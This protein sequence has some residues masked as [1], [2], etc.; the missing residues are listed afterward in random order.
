M[1][2]RAELCE[3]VAD[4]RANVAVEVDEVA[5][6]ELPLAVREI[7]IVS[8]VA[9]GK[10]AIAA[11]YGNSMRGNGSTPIRGSEIAPSA[12]SQPI[13]TAA[14]IGWRIERSAIRTRDLDL[15]RGPLTRLR[16]VRP[17][18]HDVARA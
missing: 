1:V 6:C 3:E 12:M 11:T 14:S 7:S 18:P 5:D 15:D 9:P 16:E 8:H 13:I 17:I 10:T 4:D 2:G